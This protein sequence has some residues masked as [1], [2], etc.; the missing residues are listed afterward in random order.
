MTL[1]TPRISRKAYEL[2]LLKSIVELGGSALPGKELYALVESKMNLGRYAQEYD[3][4]H[5]RPKWVYDLQ[6]VRHE[7]VN[8]G[9]MDGSQRGVW[10]TTEKGRERVR[11]E[12]DSFNLDDYVSEEGMSSTEEPED[13]LELDVAEEAAPDEFTAK[14]VPESLDAIKG[15]VLID[16]TPINQ[17]VTIVNAN[18]NLILTGPPGT[19]KT[20]IAI[21][22]G[23]QA[24]RTKFI[25]GYVL[26]T[27]TSD[28]TT[29]DTIGGYV[30]QKDSRLVFSPGI[31]LR[32][33]RE[34]KWVIIDE[35]NRADVDKAF[36]QL[37]TI[38]SGQDVELP[39]TDEQGNSIKIRHAKGL[40]SYYD[41]LAVTYF[42]GD[43]WRVIGTMNTFDKNS[44]F[45]LSYAFMRRFGFV[46]INSPSTTQMHS[47]I[48]G[49][50]QDGHL[51]NTRAEKMKR[52]LEI[53]PR[54]LGPAILIDM[55]NYLKERPQPDSFFESIVAYVLPQF[56]GLPL[57]AIMVFFNQVA[58][59]LGDKENQGRMQRYLTQMFDIEPGAWEPA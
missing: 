43:N 13:V 59:D 12:W 6:W 35:I 55:L 53:T 26:T 10:K 18:R 19:G 51:D 9:E 24:M 56:E 8:R 42:V 23:E 30:P 44:L 32:A 49:R 7:L 37:L 48:D 41:E 38:L 34:N 15:Q 40:Q 29:F 4:V 46:H 52:L 33:I 22:A 16:D 21:N 45:A 25:H 17:I 47:I 1:Q 14:F 5:A 28:W 54:E 58:S 31:V 11:L 39:F 36:G 2:P 27:A 57:E 3:E 50:V 20:T